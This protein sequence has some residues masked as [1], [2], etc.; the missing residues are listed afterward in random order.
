MLEH[1]PHW[2][3]HWLR[4]LRAGHA[5][6]IAVQPGIV[7]TAQQLALSSPA[8]ADGA[9]LPERFTADGDG[10]SPPLLWDAPP[11]GTAAFALVV[12]DADAPAPHPLVHAI[13]W[14]IDPGERRLPEG[15]LSDA[16]EAAGGIVGRNSFLARGWLPPDPPTGHGSHDYVF[17]LFTLDELKDIGDA[18]GRSD[19]LGALQG[20]VIATGILT[21]TYSRGETMPLSPGAQAVPT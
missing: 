17:Q 19:V 4:G 15:A 2:L 8:F 5:G 21:G 6:L 1:V 12:E 11:D 18:P 7:T 9:R 20:H 13:L 16:T 14:R 3:G 10:V